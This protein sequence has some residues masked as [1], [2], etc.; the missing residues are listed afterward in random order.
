MNNK[1]FKST[2]TI[3]YWNVKSTAPI[4]NILYLHLT[5]FFLTL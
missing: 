4:L 2:Q 3:N 1:T 5:D